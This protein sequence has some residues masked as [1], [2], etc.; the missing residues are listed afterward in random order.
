MINLEEKINLQKTNLEKEVVFQEKAP[1]GFAGVAEANYLDRKQIQPKSG[2]SSFRLS[3]AEKAFARGLKALQQKKYPEA[4]RQ[5][6]GFL[7]L[8][9]QSGASAYGSK[10]Q[11]QPKTLQGIRVVVEALELLL[12]ISEEITILEKDGR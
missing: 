3:V 6:A 4:K 5:L 1:L 12:A 9:G 10:P 2:K 11:H 8:M 7:A